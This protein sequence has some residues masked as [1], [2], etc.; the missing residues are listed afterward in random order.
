MLTTTTGHRAGTNSLWAYFVLGQILPTSFAQNL[1][2][3][4][5]S[6]AP[7][8]QG[9]TPK[10]ALLVR[11]MVWITYAVMFW[12]V[13][14]IKSTPWF[15]P[16]IF[17]LRILLFA[18]FVVDHFA[19]DSTRNR[20]LRLDQISQAHAILGTGLCVVFALYQITAPSGTVLA[21]RGSTGSNYAAK[22]LTDD[23]LLGILS[24]TVFV[25]DSLFGARYAG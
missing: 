24:G 8:R 13:P 6:L 17:V 4:A 10:P 25:A 5:L 9:A 7:S 12:I 21:S 23:V 1:F 19:M 15:L 11:S 16:A 14:R 2:L 22:A 18:P 3:T 20:Y